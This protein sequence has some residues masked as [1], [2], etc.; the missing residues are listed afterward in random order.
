MNRNDLIFIQLVQNFL[1]VGRNKHYTFF[2]QNQINKCKTVKQKLICE[3]N[4]PLPINI[5]LSS[6]FL[7]FVTENSMPENC[8]IKTI[9]I[10]NDIWHQ[11]KSSNFGY[12]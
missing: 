12:M 3:S 9:P 5:K 2:T 10:F 7:L 4:M 6:E 1:A 11:L 8:E